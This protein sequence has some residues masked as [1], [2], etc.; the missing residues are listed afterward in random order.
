MGGDYAPRETTLGAIAAY[1]EL[2]KDVKLVLMGD[3]EVMLPVFKEQSVPESAF[4]I[5]HTTEVIEMNDHPTKSFQQKPKSS[6]ACRL[7]SS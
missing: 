3:K 1:H 7:S 5:I 2:P 4:E 6:L